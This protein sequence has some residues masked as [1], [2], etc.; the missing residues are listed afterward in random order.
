MPL[1][2]QIKV[3]LNIDDLETIICPNCKGSVFQ[4]DLCTFKKLP[5]VQSPTGKAQ[6][7]KINIITCPDCKSQFQIRDD[8]LFPISLKGRGKEDET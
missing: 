2:Q 4:T 7:I 8:N 6:L 1:K 5:S 3:S